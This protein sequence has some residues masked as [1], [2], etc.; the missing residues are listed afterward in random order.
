MRTRIPYSL[1]VAILTV[2][3]SKILIFSLGYAMVY[4]AQGPA[5]PLT[6]IMNQFSRWDS[7]HYLDLAKNWYV[8]QGDPANF[9]VFFPLY[10]ILIRLTT[11]SF[12]YM[13]LSAL[14]V[15]NV[16]AFIASFFLYK[17]AKLDFGDGVATK[18]VLFMSIFPTAYF[19]SAIYTEGLFFALI[20][21]SLYYGRVGQWSLA[22]FLSMFAALTRL[23]GL[24]LLPA[25]AVEYLHQKGWKIRNV[26]ANILWI[27]LSFVGFLIYLNINNQVTGNPF[28]FVEIER[29][30][31]YTT[32]NP[33]LGVT[34][35]FQWA[36]SKPYPS[37]III[38]VAQIAFAA[39]GFAVIVAGFSTRLRLSYNVYMVLAWVL[40]VSGSWWLSVPRYVMAMF[41]MFIVFGLLSRRRIVTLAVAISSLALLCFFT[42]LFAQGQFAF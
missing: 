15:S 5:A 17:L 27:G 16:S 2:I 1:R 41:P 13:N 30:H 36:I 32:L 8:N 40:A 24:L 10:P 14:I 29:V 25:L 28:M 19:F 6:I 22:G 23:G 42:I 38:G 26:Q 4:F 3:L 20:I 11:I 31:W 33:I 37:N 7:P 21:A 12:T 18:A 34:N 9:I 39:F 35:A